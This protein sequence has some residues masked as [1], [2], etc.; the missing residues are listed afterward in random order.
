MDHVV[1]LDAREKEL[2][3]LISGNKSMIIRAADEKKFPQGEV[4]NGD[5][6][7]F[8]SDIGKTEVKA[9]GKVSSVMNFE[10][11]SVEESFEKIIDYQDKLQLP[12]KQFEILAGKSF[13]ML[14]ELQEILMV[15]P[16]RISQYRDSLSDDWIQVGDIQS[17]V[18]NNLK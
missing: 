6:L 3:N 9:R 5:I 13:L 10:K 1:Y 4:H 17:I 8:V 12:D 2:E 15:N 14:I 7:Y 18:L 11:L 16:F